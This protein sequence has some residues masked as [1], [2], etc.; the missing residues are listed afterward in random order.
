MYMILIICYISELPY[1]CDKNFEK[2]VS[3]KKNLKSYLRPNLQKLIACKNVFQRG[4]MGFLKE[5]YIVGQIIDIRI[6]GREF[7]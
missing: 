1:I 3:L 5:C 6:F 7:I 2:D 4:K